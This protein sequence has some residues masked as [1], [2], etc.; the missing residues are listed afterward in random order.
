MLLSDRSIKLALDK[1]QIGITPLELDDIQPASVDMHLHDEILVF[2]NSTVPYIDLKQPIPELMRK[3]TVTEEQPFILHPGEF[4]LGSTIEVLELA[5]D[6]VG[7][8]EGKSSLGR[9]GLMIH[10]TAGFIDPG[11]KGRLTL[12]LAN[13]ARLPITLY[14]GMKVC[15]VAFQ[16]LSSAAD[17]PYG[18]SQ[19]GS[20]Y[21]KQEG[22]AASKAHLDFE[23]LAARKDDN[24]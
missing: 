1:G 17:R 9:V 23:R 8:I 24:E 18:S 11:W 16:E 13:V 5:D 14:R 20:R 22:A 12:E 15:Q 2:S 19:L 21:Q 7:N 10:S 4:A 3:V 6:I